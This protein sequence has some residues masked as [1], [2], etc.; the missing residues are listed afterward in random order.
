M[1]NLLGLKKSIPIALQRN[2]FYSVQNELTNVMKNF[3]DWF[4]PFNFP[5]ERFE[6]LVITPAIDIVEDKDHFKVEAEMPGMGEEDI[7]I[8]IRDGLLTIKGEKATSKQ[9]KDKNYLMR[10]INYGS[11]ERHVSLPDS[12]D[13]DKAK[14]NF[15]K[16]M[17]WIDIPKKTEYAG[18]S[19]TIEIENV[20]RLF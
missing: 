20:E 7:K 5:I 12:V 9:D 6:D 17:L 11:Y 3:N 1:A 4:D 19:R 10:E 18:R 14:A 8:S 2:P 13:I 15:K 16:G